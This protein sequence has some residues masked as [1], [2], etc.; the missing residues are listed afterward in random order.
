VPAGGAPPNAVI[1]W[2]R[3]QVVLHSAAPHDVRFAGP[4]VSQWPYRPDDVFHCRRGHR[5]LEP[6]CTCGFYAVADPSRLGPHAVRTALLRVALEGRVVRHPGCW[7]GERQRVLGVT[8][9]GWCELCVRPAVGLAG[10]PPLF[11]VL[12]APWLRA[13]PVC[14]QD[15]RL[16]DVV[17][18]RDRLEGELGVPVLWD[19][20]A[21]SPV[22]AS[23]RR[24]N[25][26]R[27]GAAW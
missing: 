24:L 19:V 5:R 25:R 16:F 18:G 4:V 21:E 22:V 13:L 9:S 2:K 12:P 10:T 15:G 8:L 27:R 3:A 1:G 26:A 20:E 7:R 6:S 17:V 14:E 11:G 23:L